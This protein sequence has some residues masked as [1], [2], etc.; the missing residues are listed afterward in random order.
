MTIVNSKTPAPRYS[1]PAL[2]CTGRAP[3]TLALGAARESFLHA[4]NYRRHGVLCVAERNTVY[5]STYHVFYPSVYNGTTG[6]TTNIL[7]N[8]M[9]LNAYNATTLTVFIDDGTSDHTI[10]RTVPN[11]SADFTYTGYSSDYGQIIQYV[12]AA[13][14]D[15]GAAYNM[16]TVTVEGGMVGA[17]TAVSVPEAEPTD[18]GQFYLDPGAFNAGM[19]L[20]GYDR[21]ANVV[22]GSVDALVHHQNNRGASG[23]QSSTF[24]NCSRTCLFGWAAPAGRFSGTTGTGYIPLMSTSFRPFLYRRNLTRG[25]AAVK[26][27]VV[28]AYRAD[29]GTKIKLESF[30]AGDSGGTA[31]ESYEWTP[32]AMTDPTPAIAISTQTFDIPAETSEIKVSLYRTSTAAFELHGL[33]IF[34]TTMGP[35]V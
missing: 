23:S 27:D 19:P 6:N 7:I 9:C 1:D 30:V 15:M 16:M 21:S 33:A 8:V 32:G 14:M 24:L 31:V 17:F 28:I 22:T 3:S 18:E 13:T 34:D 20:M 4:G 5:D 29:T 10:T 2:H 11:N 12:F 26:C 35:T 25:S